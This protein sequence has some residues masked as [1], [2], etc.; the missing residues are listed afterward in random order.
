VLTLLFHNTAGAIPVAT[1]PG[2]ERLTALEDLVLSSCGLE[3]SRLLCMTTGL[4]N[5]HLGE[6]TLDPGQVQQDGES[7]TAQ[8]LQLLARLCSLRELR[9]HMVADKWPRQLSLYSALTASS[10]LQVLSVRDCDIPGAAWAHAFPAGRKLP[11]LLEFAALREDDWEPQE[12]FSVD[13][14][15]LDRLVSCAP[16]LG[17]LQIATYQGASLAPLESLTALTAL[18]IAP[19]AASPA[20]FCSELT[21]LTRLQALKVT[22]PD[23][24]HDEPAGLQH[25]VPLTA[26]T[27]L[28]CLDVLQADEYGPVAFGDLPMLHDV[29][30]MTR[31]HC[32]RFAWVSIMSWAGFCCCMAWRPAGCCP[33]T[34]IACPEILL[35]NPHLTH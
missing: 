4:T 17:K 8:L 31:Q 18:T 20:A 22:F 11:C 21:T 33:V 28:T 12:L 16:A 25:L 32:H 6:V 23:L 5:L 3:T 30:S 1:L 2:I 19:V 34:R 27:G 9:L 26:L 10:D 14:T 15:V 29:V 35:S 7:A 24:N 13:S